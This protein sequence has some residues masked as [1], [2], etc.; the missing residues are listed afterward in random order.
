[1]KYAPAF[2]TLVKAAKAQ[3]C[4]VSIA[5]VKARIDA[6][7]VFLLIDIRE[8]SEWAAGHLPQAQYLGRGVLEREIEAL[9]PD[10]DA[11]IVLYCAGG[12]RS[13]LSAE[14]LGKMG[15]RRVAS[16]AGGYRGWKELGLAAL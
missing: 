7:E 10:F 1:M 15:Y 5:A 16:M 13:A 4:E 3:V 9:A 11:D 6:G 2:D 12:A 8:E 14:S